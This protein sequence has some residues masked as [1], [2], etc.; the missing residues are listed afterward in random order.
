MMVVAKADKFL[1]ISG[2]CRPTVNFK[3][4]W[5]QGEAPLPEPPLGKIKMSAQEEAPA[6]DADVTAVAQAVQAAHPADIPHLLRSLL[7]RAVH[8]RVVGPGLGR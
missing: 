4:V 8:A 2:R 7:Y 5:Q 6:V 3:R 1:V